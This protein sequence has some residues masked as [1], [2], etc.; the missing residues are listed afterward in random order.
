MKKKNLALIAIAA[1]SLTGTASAQTTIRLTGSTAFRGATMTAIRNILQ[2]GYTFAYAGNANINSA[3]E[4]IFTGTTV[5][6]AGPP[7][8][9]ATPVVIKVSWGGSTGGLQTVVQNLTVSSDPNF[10]QRHTAQRRRHRL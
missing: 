8:S 3:S 7:A 1:A 9:P 5:A 2:P 4:A 10:R 6:T